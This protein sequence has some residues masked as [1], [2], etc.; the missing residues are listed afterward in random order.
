MKYKVLFMKTEQEYIK[1]LTEIRSMMERSS[2]F[3]TLTGWPGIMAGI[4]ALAGVLIGYRL[5]YSTSG[6]TVYNSLDRQEITGNVLNIFLLA[7]IVLA[8]AVGTAIYIP[9][10]KS[11]LS[12][13][14]LWNAA[15]R[16]MVINMAIPLIT[17]GIFI[18]ILFFKGLLGLV[19]PL[20]LLFYGLALLNA[21]KYTYEEVKFLGLA[22]IVLGLLATYFI[23]YGLLFWTLG[24]GIMHIIY[25][26]YMHLSYEK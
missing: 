18:I 15:A 7:L 8:L 20:T 25:G 17:G 2:K 22:Q 16:R 14:R 10:R 12:G 21:S 3:L 9:Y 11:K 26:I 24:F 13:E 6:E 5:F 1:D 19:A 4:Y 23:G